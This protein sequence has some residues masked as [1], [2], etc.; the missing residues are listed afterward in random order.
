M[1]KA[2]AI[3]QAIMNAAQAVT[4]VWA[5]WGWP[6]GAIF[7]ALT[8]V[9]T[10]IEI[11]KIRSQ[12]IP[13]YEKGRIPVYN[14]GHIPKDHFLAYIGSKEAVINAE[15]TRNN[16]DLLKFINSHPGEKVAAGGVNIYQTKHLL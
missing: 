15:S 2:L 4:K 5:Q 6:L 13:S 3:G 16:L 9:A 14:D 11:D 8:S 7:A 1:G 10:G 12:M